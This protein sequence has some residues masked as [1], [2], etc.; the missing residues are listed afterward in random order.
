MKSVYISDVNPAGNCFFMCISE[1]L[2]QREDHY[3]AI[4]DFA[5]NNKNEIAE[6]IPNVEIQNN[7]IIS[8]DDYISKIFINKY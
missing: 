4:Y 3:I 1:F 5:K 6:F 8:T 7:I 2:F